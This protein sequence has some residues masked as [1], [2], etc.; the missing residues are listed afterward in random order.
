MAGMEELGFVTQDDEVWRAFVSLCLSLSRHMFY[1]CSKP[2]ESFPAP[3]AL[4]PA[5]SP[6]VARTFFTHNAV[7][8]GELSTRVLLF[9]PLYVQGKAA[10]RHQIGLC[11]LLV[12]CQVSALSV[13]VYDGRNA[14]YQFR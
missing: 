7:C 3:P 14:L 4:L 8:A 1:F 12:G 6:L 9:C 5:A 13:R 10:E 2:S 11:L